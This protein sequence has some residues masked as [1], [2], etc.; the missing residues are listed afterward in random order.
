V[1]A[2][3]A[4]RATGTCVTNDRNDD[5]GNRVRGFPRPETMRAFCI[6][7]DLCIAR[8]VQSFVIGNTGKPD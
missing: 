5:A 8:I 4:A 6:S 1:P 3:Q 2:A 7:R